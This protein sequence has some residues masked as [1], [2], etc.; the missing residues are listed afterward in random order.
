MLSYHQWF[1]QTVCKH[2]SRRLVLQLDDVILGELS[3]IVSTSVDMLS[4]C[5]E[6]WILGKGESPL[7]VSID[8]Y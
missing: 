4:A 6:L 5:V 1:C 8:R 2:L 3:D 7:I